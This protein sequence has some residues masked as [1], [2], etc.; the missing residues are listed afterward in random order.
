MTVSLDNED[1]Y[2]ALS[3]YLLNN[4]PENNVT[5]AK[6]GDITANLLVTAQDDEVDLSLALGN[7]NRV[8]NEGIIQATSKLSRYLGKP[9][10]DI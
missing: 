10:F 6:I 1:D 7:A 5:A 2:L 3:V 4:L 9:K 8:R